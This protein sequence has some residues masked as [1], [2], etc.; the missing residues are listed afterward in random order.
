MIYLTIIEKITIKF[1]D[2]IF[3]I[4]KNFSINTICKQVF[5]LREPRITNRGEKLGL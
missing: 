3:D 5:N 1:Q 4:H 2:K